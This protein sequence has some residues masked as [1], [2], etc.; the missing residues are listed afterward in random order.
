MMLCAV[1]N[2]RGWRRPGA[3]ADLHSLM[4][5]ELCRMVKMPGYAFIR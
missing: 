3:A 1:S 5:S 2:W 4:I